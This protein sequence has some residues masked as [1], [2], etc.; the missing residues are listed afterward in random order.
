MPLLLARTNAS[1]SIRSFVSC[2]TDD[3]ALTT[4]YLSEPSEPTSNVHESGVSSEPPGPN[5]VSL[6]PD[7]VSASPLLM[8][9]C[10]SSRSLPAPLPSESTW[11]PS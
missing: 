11:S 5:C 1:A 3:H 7:T 10:Q 2:S 6:L 8:T 9:V 4:S